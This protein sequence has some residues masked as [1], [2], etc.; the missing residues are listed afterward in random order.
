MTTAVLK[1]FGYTTASQ[2]AQ[3]LS[4]LRHG[5]EI[6]QLDA[7]G[8]F[9]CSRL[10]ARINDLRAAGHPIVSELRLTPGGKRVAFYRYLT[11]GEQLRLGVG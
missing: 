10:A 4:T 1:E 5:E 9:R 11:S 3:I 2:S 6:T 7:W 8:R